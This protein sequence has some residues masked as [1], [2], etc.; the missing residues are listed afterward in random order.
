MIEL[1]LADARR[2]AVGAQLLDGRAP[3]TVTE[4]VRALG[5]VQVDPVASVARAEHMILFSRLGPYDLTEL[6]SG[7]DRG[8]LFE[9][10]AHI[11]PASDY[12]IHR[13]A[14]RRYPQGDRTRARYVRE[15]LAANAAFRRYV[16]RELRRRGPILS[17]DLEDRCSVQWRTGGWNDGKGLGR[18]LDILW[19]RGEIAI[20]G[21]QG[22][23]RVWDLASR[24]LPQ[25]EAR[26]RQSD[27]AHAVV[28]R[29]LRRR[30]VARRDEFG[31]MFD[32]VPPG[33]E[34][35][36]RSL[37]RD[38]IAVPAHVAGLDGEW[39]AH[40]DVIERPPGAARTVLLSPFDR[41][42]Y[43][44]E[45]T[46][47]LFGFR[48]RLGMYLTPSKR[49]FGYYVLPIL[50]GTDLIGR[51][52]ATFDRRARLLRVDGVWAERGTSASVDTDVAGA[53]HELATW[54][55]VDDVKIGGLIPR[56]WAR[57]LRA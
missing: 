15:W 32:G 36:F 37:V 44:R 31:W 52:D 12:G 22:T 38:G 41:L 55:G 40:R 2:V 26:W 46:A 35:A 18:M 53:L 42:V 43:D 3:G 4:V 45:R 13:E 28:E 50:H 8:E 1:S 56:A 6:A 5:S 48:Y 54:L 39:W 11:V 47:E 23:E 29:G 9:Y 16:L 17:R 30:G 25:D 51:V 20:V 19:L 57:A 24:R 27:V 33:A 49:E 10:W 14:M 7:L 34:Q 21:R